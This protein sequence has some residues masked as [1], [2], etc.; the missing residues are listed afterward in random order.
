M[1]L[2]YVKYRDGS[3]DFIVNGDGD[4]GLIIG[5]KEGIEADPNIA[6]IIFDDSKAQAILVKNKDN[7]SMFEDLPEDVCE[8]FRDGRKTITV[9]EVTDENTEPNSYEVPIELNE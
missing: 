3:G 4:L 8:I 1:D 7:L 2:D 9:I 5:A 6:K